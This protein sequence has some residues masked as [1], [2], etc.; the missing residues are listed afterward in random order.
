MEKK[1]DFITEVRLFYADI[2]LMKNVGLDNATSEVNLQ[3]GELL[4]QFFQS[5]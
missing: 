4:A 3:L 5:R 2:L 1:P